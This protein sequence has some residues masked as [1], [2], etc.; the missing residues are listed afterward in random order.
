M[1]GDCAWVVAKHPMMK[2]EGPFVREVLAAFAD[3]GAPF[4]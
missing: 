3:L 2:P 1:K 4:D